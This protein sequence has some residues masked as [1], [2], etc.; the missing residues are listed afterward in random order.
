MASHH[1]IRPKRVQMLSEYIIP[2]S[3]DRHCLLIPV[4]LAALS[5]YLVSE[6]MQLVLG[7]LRTEM[8]GYEI[9]CLATYLLCESCFMDMIPRYF[10]ATIDS[11]SVT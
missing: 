8:S 11:R 9:I 4:G 2:S 6:A 10:R 7:N 1:Y 3:W 5:L